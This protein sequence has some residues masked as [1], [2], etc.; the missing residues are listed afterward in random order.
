MGDKAAPPSN[1]RRYL[2]WAGGAVGAVG[3]VSVATPFVLTMTPSARA[4]AA[5]APVEVDLSK[6]EP[7]MMVTVEWRGVPVWIIHRTPEM[8]AAIPKLNDKVADPESTQ[9]VQ[10]DDVNKEQRSIKPEWLVLVG[11]CTHLGCS[12]S[13]K[14]KA[15]AD[16]GLGDDW[17]GGF[18]CPCHG[19]KFD[20]AGR[21]FKGMPAPLNLKVPPYRYL[22]DTHLVVGEDAKKGA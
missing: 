22:S 14:L 2:L 16:S 7:G 21:V 9:S 18:Y 10:P 17:M 15:G 1:S 11:I 8:L 3:A 6:I 5:G 20:V 4:L 12:P 13:E 19:S